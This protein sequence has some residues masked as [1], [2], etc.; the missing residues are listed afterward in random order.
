MPIVTLDADLPVVEDAKISKLNTSKLVD[1]Y[2]VGCKEEEIPEQKSE[3]GV[4][5]A[6]SKIVEVKDSKM[7]TCAPF[8]P[9]SRSDESKNHFL[10]AVVHAYNNHLSLR[11]SPD[12]ILHCVAMAVSNC[13]NDHSEEYRDVFVNHAGKKKL[14]VKVATPPGVFNWDQLLDLMSGLIDENVKSSLGLEPSF[15]TT[16]RLSKSVAALTKMASFKKYFSY[17]FMMCCGIR[18]VDLTGTLNDWLMLR[19]KVG[20]ATGLMTSKGHMV[21]WSTHVLVLID[22]LIETYQVGDGVLSNDLKTFW[23]RIVTYVPYGS[24]GERYISGWIK[25]LVPGD[26]YDKFPEKCNL[27]DV[28]SAEPERIR[29]Y[30]A[31]Q[32]IM[33]AWAGMTFDAPNSYTFAEAELNDHGM[34]YDLYCMSGFVGMQI[35]NGFVQPQLGYTVHATKKDAPDITAEAETEASRVSEL[36]RQNAMLRGTVGYSDLQD[37]NLEVIRKMQR[38]SDS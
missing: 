30:Y 35:L 17:G 19:E 1:L 8:E 6:S 36:T 26:Q 5:P 14:V 9:V 20:H 12:D 28:H 37:A 34:V 16:T 7:I 24:G 29:N 3:W 27:L 32:D 38:V 23:S 22:R 18:A 31:W 13:I 11:I 10:N 2:P 15:S 33:K 25:F 4:E 21:N